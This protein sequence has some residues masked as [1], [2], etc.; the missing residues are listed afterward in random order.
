MCKV[1]KISRSL[2]YYHINL[3]EKEL[4]EEYEKD[5]ISAFKESN[6]VYGAKKIRN[7]L[8][9][10]DIR[11]SKRRIRRI[12]EKNGLVSTYT[13]AQFKVHKTEVNQDK[14]NNELNR[15]FNDKEEN[16]VIVSDLT[17]VRV[18][19]KYICILLDIFNR[20][21]I[22]YSAG[23]NKD[24][25]LVELAFMNSTIPLSNI[26]LFHTDRGSEFKNSNIDEILKAFNIKR[27]LS[28][29]GCPYDNAVAEATYKII[30][31]EFIRGRKFE[32]LEQLK[33]ELFDYINWYNTKRIHGS[34][35]YLSPVEYRLCMSI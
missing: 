21:I 34:L 9:K 27:S 29:P 23:E 13:I 33:T 8:R 12:M 20:E 31:T 19:S 6:N 26:Q 17:Y 10:R 28:K 2:Y 4:K 30:K 14:I 15:E 22:G 18:G 32:S 7:E 3:V 24:A 11:I 5:V 1:L 16:Q 25:K 35:G